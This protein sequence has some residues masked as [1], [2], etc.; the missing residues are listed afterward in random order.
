M[1]ATAVAHEFWLLPPRFFVTAGDKI[2]LHVFV[3]GS[4]TGSRWSGKSTRLTSFVH[5]A[6][7]DTTDLTTLAT[8]ADTLNTSVELR[9]P[10]VHLLAF[11]TTNAFVEL[12]GPKFTAY[13][14]ENGL[15][16]T[17]AQRQQRGEAT[18]PGRELYR[19]C[20]KTL[21]QAG[22]TRPDTLRTFARHTAQPLEIVPEQNPYA[23]KPNAS[24]TCLV[25]YK[26]QPLPASLVQV[27]QRAAGQ[28]TVVSKLYTNKNGR[29]LFRLNSTGNYMVSTVYM[30]PAADRKTADW[31]ST[32]ATLTFGIAGKGLK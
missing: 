2:N 28:P 8:R 7:H 24:L 18:T 10:G 20:A 6:P 26:G 3:G 1:A 30:E 5:Y 16:R 15:E 31:Q 9:Q 4:F 32:W 29:V 11:S 21:V 13:L 22:P 25:L 19:R 27:W 23:L 14:Q 17:I 12:D